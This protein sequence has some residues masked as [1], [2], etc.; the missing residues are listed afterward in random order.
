MLVTELMTPYP[1]IVRFD[2]PIRE[3]AR[4]MVQ[5]SI[6]H[7]PVVGPR[8]ELVGLL[9]DG[10]VFRQGAFLDVDR[11]WVAFE[12]R[13]EELTCGA[14]AVPADVVV[15]P[16]LDV[17]SVLRRL[18]A[19]GQDAA[20]V[21]NEG[22]HPIGVVS[23]HDVLALALEVLDPMLSA[24]LD[25]T[26]D[27]TSLEDAEP[28]AAALELMLEHGFRHVP[29]TRGGDIVGVVSM[30]DLVAEDARHRPELVLDQ[31]L[32]LASPVTAPYG[33]SLREL[34]ARMKVNKVGSVPLLDE[35]GFVAGI[36]TRRDVLEA[37]LRA[38]ETEALFPTES[39]S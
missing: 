26:R 19:T 32:R 38:L 8:G 1:E 6:R 36:A 31:V 23:E 17:T 2:V 27:V 28:A 33:T 12:Q 16:E 18:S 30:R 22:S 3:A 10:E 4:R 15:G 21:V 34:A 39:A 25:G 20:V 9:D 35:R 24:S 14:V 13:A 37:T 29:V 11:G 5:L 7:L